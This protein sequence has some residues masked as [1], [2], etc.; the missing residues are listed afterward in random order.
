MSEIE[1]RKIATEEASI[2]GIC[3]FLLSTFLTVAMLMIVYVGSASLHRKN[4][5]LEKRITE[6]EIKLNQQP[7]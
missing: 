6:L 7:K 4:E 2:E 3:V 1:V 5:S